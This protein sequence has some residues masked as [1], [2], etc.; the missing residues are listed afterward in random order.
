[1]YKE[2]DARIRDMALRVGITDRAVQTILANLLDDGVVEIAKIGR[3]NY[4][5]IYLETKLK[6]SIENMHSV[7]DLLRIL[8]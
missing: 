6:R 2:P 1:L 7:G 3:R 4:Y 8:S 5:T